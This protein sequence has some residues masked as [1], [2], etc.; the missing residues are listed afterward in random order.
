MFRRTWWIPFAL[1]ALPVT[2]D[3]VV[4]KNGN[5]VRG[6]VVGTFGDEVVVEVDKIRVGIK[7][8]QIKEIV[9]RPLTVRVTAA[10]SG[11]P[12]GP[13][14][15]PQPK[16]KDQ[17]Q[18]QP[19]PRPESKKS[20]ALNK[21]IEEALNR[22]RS[23]ARLGVLLKEEEYA[24]RL[25]RAA[26]N[27]VREIA[28]VIERFRSEEPQTARLA[29]LSLAHI[30]SE[31]AFTALRTYGQ[32]KLAGLRAAAAVALAGSPRKNAASA[33][34]EMLGDRNSDVARAA[35]E[36][37]R[38]L[39]ERGVDLQD[40]LTRA[41]EHRD[42]STRMRVAACLG[43]IGK[44]W[45]CS[46]LVE[47]LRDSDETVLVAAVQ[48]LAR[49]GGEDAAPEVARMLYD[50]RANVRREAALALGQMGSREVVADLIEKL[51]D[52]EEGV[53]QNA[54]WSLHR[55]TSEKLDADYER[56]KSWW[57]S[58]NK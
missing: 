37:L 12:P 46:K 55:L 20:E 13:S 24:A 38:A 22:Y 32:D 10:K 7:K 56:W 31:E 57:D 16:L 53:R 39:H 35:L 18:P 11:E 6:K 30:D 27:D 9:E 44:A 52:E 17:P 43:Y 26:G 28:R 48:S 2:A 36:G 23:D 58:I 14:A 3:D 50:D 1:V 45:A 54:L 25:A 8:G 40:T 33:L 34:A 51:R 42:P 4:L 29:L 21:E 49:C 5:T 41:S 19:R 15:R 47:L